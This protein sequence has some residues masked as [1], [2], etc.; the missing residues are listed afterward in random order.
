MPV[1]PRIVNDD[2]YVT[3]INHACHSTGQ[4]Q[5]LV[6]LDVA[7]RIVND[8]SYVTRINDA[9]HFSWQAQHLVI[10]VY[11]TCCSAHCK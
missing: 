11:D 6:R 7:P 1:A 8:I 2:S 4:A 3:R 5:H 10:L 9:S